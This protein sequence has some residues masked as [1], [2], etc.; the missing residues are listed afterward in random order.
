MVPKIW[1][2][3]LPLGL[4]ATEALSPRFF[5]HFC[6]GERENPLITGKDEYVE[7]EGEEEKCSRMDEISRRKK[8]RRRRRRRRRV[9]ERMGV[10]ICRSGGGERERESWVGGLNE[11]RERQ[12]C[13]MRQKIPNDILCHFHSEQYCTL[14]LA[15]LEHASLVYW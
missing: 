8:G 7:K 9:S 4:V 3:R 1:R 12:D 13:H 14:H 11:R 15:R 5:L 6:V 10:D 2:A